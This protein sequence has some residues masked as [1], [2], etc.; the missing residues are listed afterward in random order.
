MRVTEILQTHCRDKG[1]KNMELFKKKNGGLRGSVR[2]VCT[3]S[4]DIKR[5]RKSLIEPLTTTFVNHFK[6]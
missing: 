3:I 2:C 5:R 6:E 1:E 4:G